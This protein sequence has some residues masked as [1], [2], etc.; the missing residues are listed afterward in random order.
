MSNG[1]IEKVHEKT[2]ALVEQHGIKV[3]QSFEHR[4]KGFVCEVI[5]VHPLYG[6]VVSNPPILH[7]DLS[8]ILD[9]RKLP[10][11]TTLECNCCG[12]CT[13]GRQW[14]NRDDGYGIC[15]S[16]GNEQ[17]EHYGLDRVNE[18]NGRRGVYWGLAQNRA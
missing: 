17:A 18:W 8:N 1:Y 13:K 11:I 14:W 2:K 16:C 7:Q 9:F 4:E 6:W 12:L 3:G 15:E 10:R 5:S